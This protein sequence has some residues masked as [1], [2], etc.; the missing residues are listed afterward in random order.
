MYRKRSGKQSRKPSRR[1]Q[2]ISK[3]QKRVSTHD[4]S[5]KTEVLWDMDSRLRGND[6]GVSLQDRVIPGQAGI[7][8]DAGK[9]TSKYFL[10]LV[11]VIID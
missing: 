9:K 8:V 2:L 10:N 3:I 1:S 7:H 5:Y 6:N 11:Y 4:V